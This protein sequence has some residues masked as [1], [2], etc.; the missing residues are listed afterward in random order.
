MRYIE[1]QENEAEKLLEEFK[2][3]V[4]QHN[5][6]VKHDKKAAKKQRKAEKRAIK[7]LEV[8]QPDGKITIVDSNDISIFSETVHVCVSITY[9]Y[10]SR[11]YL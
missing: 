1:A 4:S 10:K 6:D 8:P 5:A 11:P 9:I 3:E 2:L 7:E